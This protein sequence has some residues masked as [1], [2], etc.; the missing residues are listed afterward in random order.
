L[1][2]VTQ[3]TVCWP[4]GTVGTVLAK[5]LSTEVRPVLDRSL[6]GLSSTAQVKEGVEER[7]SNPRKPPRT[8]GSRQLSAAANNRAC[9]RATRYSRCSIGVKAERV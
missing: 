7:Q 8:P 1:N 6:S 9:Q 2:F 4:E 5:S 3:Q